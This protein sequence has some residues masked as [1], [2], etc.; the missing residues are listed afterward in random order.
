MINVATDPK[1]GKILVDASG[2]TLYIYTKDG[3]NQSNCTDSCLDITEGY[4]IL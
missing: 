4:P 3:P 1:L 2:M